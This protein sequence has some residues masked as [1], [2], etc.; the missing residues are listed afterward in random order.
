MVHR[1][2]YETQ[3]RTL[4]RKVENGQVDSSTADAIEQMCDA[5]DEEVDSE[6]CPA[7]ENHRAVKT[8]DMYVRRL[9]LTAERMGED[10]TDTTA[11]ALN[12]EMQ[13][14]FDGTHP[15]VSDAGINENTVSNYQGP[16]RVFYRFHD[17]G[18]D[19]DDIDITTPTTTRFDPS[20]MLT[21]A[22]LQQVRETIANPRDRAIFE[23]LLNTGTRN[24][25]ARTITIDG[26][27]LA[28]GTFHLNES[29]D[30][31]KG[32]AERGTER[33]LLGAEPAVRDWLRHHP[34]SENPDAHLFTNRP[35][36]PHLDPMTPISHTHLG[37]V[38]RRIKRDSSI[39]KPMH[40][41]ALRHNFVTRAKQDYD[42]DDTTI[43][44]LIGHPADSSVMERTYQ[45]ISPEVHVEEAVSAAEGTSSPD[46]RGLTPQSCT[47]CGSPL[48]AAAETCKTCGVVY[49]PAIGVSSIQ[50]DPAVSPEEVAAAMLERPELRE[51]LVSE[52]SPRSLDEDMN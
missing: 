11:E 8:L 22:E 41:H 51:Q 9:R 2:E 13:S 29:A 32:A 15:D 52:L 48:N 30:G 19:P 49:S 6:P 38:L 25:A 27:D 10:L 16:L 36:S 18:V 20:D 7:G 43:K 33:P 31:L 3:R 35:G 42:M 34:A 45:H 24:T 39:E 47:G 4:T 14:W 37:K 28:N 23:F 26:I 50:A 1:D 5:F 17:F 46:R 40:P 21:D 44:Y 12:R